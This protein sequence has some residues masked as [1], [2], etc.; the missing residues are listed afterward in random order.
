MKA[1]HHDPNRT[2]N[3]IIIKN[4]P[5]NASDADILLIV[6]TIGVPRDIYRPKDYHTN[7]PRKFAFIDFES[8]IDM[9]T[10]IKELTGC[11]LSRHTLVVEI[12][13]TAFTSNPS[14]R[15]KTMETGLTA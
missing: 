7:E 9:L 12:P 4:L 11:Q 1:R 10:S 15:K 5:P 13:N 8:P 2:R 14:Q 3:S 6:S